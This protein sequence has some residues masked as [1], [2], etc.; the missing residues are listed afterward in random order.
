MALVV[1][2][3][4]TL[5]PSRVAHATETPDIGNQP[6]E[7]NYVFPLWGKDL[8]KKGMKFPFPFGIGVTYLEAIQPIDV[9]N[10]EV[11]INDGD[12]VDV[13]RFVKFESLDSNVQAANARLDLWVLPFLN[14]YGLANWLIS[15]E[16]DAV[17]SK[18]FPLRAGSTQTGYGGGFGATG[19]FGFWGIFA[20]VDANFTWN[21][22]SNLE[23]PVRT[24]VF[25]PR[26][27]KRFPI[28]NTVAV[29]GWIGAM[30]QDVQADTSGSIKLA[31]AV[32]DKNEGTV[33]GEI[34]RWYRG[35]DSA[36][37][38]SVSAFGG[39]FPTTGGDRDPTIHYKLDKALAY[40][41]NGLVGM[42]FD[43]NRRW[44]IRTELGFFGR[45]QMLVGVNYR[46][47]LIGD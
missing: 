24:F 9:K 1:L 28:T 36:D 18:P 12:F 15:T 19:A 7:W 3:L 5:A 16:G 6:Y 21:Q 39:R 20:T 37:R 22:L 29:S 11:A 23:S 8:A 2:V 17:L 38:A 44:Q 26:V 30:R 32:G 34:A 47:S 45:T 13:S 43:F 35:L 40:P 10:L 27:G 4:A 25:A 14:V 46:F 33:E 42:D 41:W 31:D